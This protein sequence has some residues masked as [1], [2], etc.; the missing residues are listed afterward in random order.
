MDRDWHEAR[1]MRLECHY[2]KHPTGSVLVEYGDTKVIVS[3][4]AE[5]SVPGWLRNQKPAK[6]WLTAEYSLMP[7][8]TNT[9]SKRERNHVSGRTQEI[10][11]L[12]G[13]SLRGILDLSLCPDW[14]FTV[15]CDVLQADGGTRT[16]AI[17]GAYVALELAVR[18][19]IRDKKLV[20]SPIIEGLSAISVGMLKGQILVDLDYSE[21]SV[22]DVDMNIIR[23]STSKRF[24]EVQGSAEGYSFSQSELVGMIDSC[25][26]TL[27]HVADIQKQALEMN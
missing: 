2:L 23:T 9:R 11:R 10:Q 17:S 15:D 16:A 7:G 22:A 21:D 25:A 1:P 5:N 18:Q 8:S 4:N 3:V 24:L 12:I 14:T 13:R 6:G 19:L 26:M 20:K 27:D